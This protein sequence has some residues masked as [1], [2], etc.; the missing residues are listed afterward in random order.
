MSKYVSFI[1][2]NDQIKIL[3]IS[4]K[5]G[6]ST[7]VF[8]YPSYSSKSNIQTYI[9]LYN[10]AFRK[11]F[12]VSS[13]VSN[14][15]SQNYEFTVKDQTIDF[16]DFDI[17]VICSVDKTITSKSIIDR[18]K[19]PI[20]GIWSIEIENNLN[21]L[22]YRVGFPNGQPTLYIQSHVKKTADD[23]L[24]DSLFTTIVFPDLFT[25]LMN[26]CFF[27]EASSE[28]INVEGIKE[29][30]LNWMGKSQ[31]DIDEAIRDGLISEFLEECTSIYTKNEQFLKQY[32]N[33]I[34]LG[35][36]E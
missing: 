30:S 8:S 33:S 7:V 21:G 29:R 24:N 14:T 5:Q 9:G 28:Y 15:L 3:S 35:E 31:Q 27:T 25:K 26:Y 6:E 20:G 13:L 16:R 22:L 2:T 4:R 23:L 36:D 17:Q 10:R 11:T 1:Q 19:D 34:K 18:C 12:N 32:Y